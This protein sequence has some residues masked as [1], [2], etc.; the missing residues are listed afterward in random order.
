MPPLHQ[1][2]KEIKTDHHKSRWVVAVA[3]YR[4]L[5][6]KRKLLGYSRLVFLSFSEPPTLSSF[7]LVNTGFK[8]VW[9]PVLSGFSS[10]QTHP[11]SDVAKVGGVINISF[12]HLGGTEWN[13]RLVDLKANGRALN[14]HFPCSIS[15]CLFLFRK[16]KKAVFFRRKRPLSLIRLSLSLCPGNQLRLCLPFLCRPLLQEIACMLRAGKLM[17][18]LQV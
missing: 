17:F 2:G 4:S 9:N 10:R 18:L 8:E 1:H 3:Q 12:W 7:L 5:S 14:C 16:K 13:Q 11:S 15:S 6:F